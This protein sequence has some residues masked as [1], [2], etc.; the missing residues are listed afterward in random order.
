MTKLTIQKSGI[1]G[2]TQRQAEVLCSIDKLIALKPYAPSF[3]EIARDCGSAKAYVWLVVERL[4]AEGWV[5]YEPG[6]AR[7][8]RLLKAVPEFTEV[9]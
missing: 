3:D 5:T 7:S 4:K 6:I 1:P 2:L 8:L 9:A